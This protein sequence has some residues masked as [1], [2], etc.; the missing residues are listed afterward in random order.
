MFNFHSLMAWL[1]I[2]STTLSHFIQQK[3]QII[4]AKMLLLG[5]LFLIWLDRAVTSADMW[6]DPAISRKACLLKASLPQLF[7]SCLE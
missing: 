7:E 4:V 6:L 3:T 2:Y 1:N 5:M